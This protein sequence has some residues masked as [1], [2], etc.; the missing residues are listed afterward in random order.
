MSG[1]ILQPLP[2][3]TSDFEALRLR[4]QIYAD[5]TDR[6]YKT[7]SCWGKFCLLRPRRFG[8]SLLISAFESLFKHGLREFQGLKI[9]KLWKDEAVYRVVRLDFSRIRNFTSAEEF[10]RRLISFLTREFAKPG[11][12]TTATD[13]PAFCDDL[14]GW[15]DSLPKNS[16]VLLID[17]YDAPLS[18]CLKNP[19]LF[20]AVRRMLLDFYRAVGLNED[21]FRFFFITG[22]LGFNRTGVFS[23]MKDFSD[24]T[25][26]PEYGSLLGFTPEE[27]EK[28]F[29]GYLDRACELLHIGRDE[30]LR[31]LTARY[32]GYCFE[33]TASQQ[34]IAPWSLLKFLTSPSEGFLDYWVESGGNPAAL[35]GYMKS[36]LLRDPKESASGRT[37]DL[38]DLSFA[39]DALAIPDA[40]FLIRTGYLTLKKV[41]GTTAYADYPNSEVRTALEE[42]SDSGRQ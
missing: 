36:C 1:K 9:E 37:A 21:V 6:V 32:G 2:L 33:R 22:I 35:A 24:L 29:G 8:K 13:L 20:E 7:A 23:E 34:V 26:D 14:S 31:E 17:E 18:A 27:V 30:L 4:N 25:L 5:K 15:L 28:Y 19:E 16:L 3:G 10:D 11:F 12:A 41:E 42:L 39:A 38:S 40:A